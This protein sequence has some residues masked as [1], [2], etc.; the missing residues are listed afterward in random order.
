MQTLEL[1]SDQFVQKQKLCPT[2]LT[3]WKRSEEGEQVTEKNGS[4]YKFLIKNSSLYRECISS[5]KMYIGRKQLVLPVECRKIVLHTAH[6]NPVA[7]HFSNKKTFAKI[8]THFFWPGV[9]RDV[10]NY[11]RSCDSCQRMSQRRTNLYR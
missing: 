10:R 1:T 8:A 2:L 9:G 4:R 6:E 11:C 5:K 3:L 7:G